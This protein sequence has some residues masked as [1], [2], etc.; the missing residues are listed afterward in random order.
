M[1]I[2]M[3]IRLL[4]GTIGPVFRSRAKLH[5]DILMHRHQLSVIYRSAPKHAMLINVDRLLVAKSHGQRPGVLEAVRIL[6]RETIVR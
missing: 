5:H 4:V 1:A 2:I 3:I 6:R